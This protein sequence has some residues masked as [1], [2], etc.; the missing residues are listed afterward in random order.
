[1]WADGQWGAVFL[2]KQRQRKAWKRVGEMITMIR[3]MRRNV[4]GLVLNK[5]YHHPVHWGSEQGIL[6]LQIV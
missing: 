1:M 2:G 6:S 3:V 5:M 4:T